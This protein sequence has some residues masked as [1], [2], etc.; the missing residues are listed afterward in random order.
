MA[1]FSRIYLLLRWF[2]A[3][4]AGLLEL[5]V[6]DTMRGLQGRLRLGPPHKAEEI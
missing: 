2:A 1:L 6:I 4:A 3:L 5:K